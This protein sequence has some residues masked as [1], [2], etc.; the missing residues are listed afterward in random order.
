MGST[1]AGRPQGVGAAELSADQLVAAL[2]CKV[3][4]LQGGQEAT[5]LGTLLGVLDQAR[6]ALA[7]QGGQGGEGCLPSAPA[8]PAPDPAAE[9]PREEELSLQLGG[10]HIPDLIDGNFDKAAGC[11]RNARSA[12]YA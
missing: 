4:Q 1:R 6:A 10:G 5:V 2:R 3:A 8:A 7:A 11:S 9:A 12:P